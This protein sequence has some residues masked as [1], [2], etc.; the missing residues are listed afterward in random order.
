MNYKLVLQVNLLNC[1]EQEEAEHLS[2]QCKVEKVNT[3]FYNI[4]FNNN[5]I[6]DIL[7][8]LIPNTII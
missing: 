3:T 7:L 4:I 1:T 8:I 5:Y 2:N 6:T